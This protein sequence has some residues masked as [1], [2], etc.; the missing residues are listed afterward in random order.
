MVAPGSNDDRRGSGPAGS[1][2]NPTSRR[3]GGK[4]ALRGVAAWAAFIV[5]IGSFILA[6]TVSLSTGPPITQ[7]SYTEFMTDVHA[8]AEL[9][10]RDVVTK[11]ILALLESGGTAHLSLRHL[12]RSRVLPR[13]GSLAA[14]CARGPRCRVTTAA[15]VGPAGARAVR[16]A[17]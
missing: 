6:I 9:A 2:P 8:D 3:P 5:V 4:S 10:P 7:R 17:C 16:S 14:G 11:A 13:F 15:R 1:P 12:D